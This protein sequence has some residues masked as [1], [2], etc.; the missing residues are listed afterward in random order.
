[1]SDTLSHI[2]DLLTRGASSALD[3]VLSKTYNQQLYPVVKLITQHATK[4]TRFANSLTSDTF[5]QSLWIW[6][7][8]VKSVFCWIDTRASP[9]ADNARNERRHASSGW[10]RLCRPSSQSSPHQLISPNHAQ[11]RVLDAAP[12]ARL[13]SAPR[14]PVLDV[15]CR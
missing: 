12:L 1:M 15:W 9:H 7:F 11:F 3:H 6:L 10:L 2:N 4:G 14:V 5:D 13:L 8:A